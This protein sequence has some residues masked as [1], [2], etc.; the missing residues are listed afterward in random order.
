MVTGNILRA[1]GVVKR[2]L[3]RRILFPMLD[4]TLL[5]PSSVLTFHQHFPFGITF[6]IHPQIEIIKSLR[7]S[8]L[9][10]YEAA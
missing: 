10:H 5:L 7:I 4:S 3:E 9:S 8:I 6:S 1:H 2:V